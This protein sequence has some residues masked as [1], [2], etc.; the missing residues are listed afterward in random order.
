[1]QFGKGAQET[2]GSGM[3]QDAGLDAAEQQTPTTLPDAGSSSS[4]QKDMRP[5]RRTK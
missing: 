3:A 1:M 4:A 5:A 2:E